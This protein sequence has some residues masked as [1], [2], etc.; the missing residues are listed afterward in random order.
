MTV[1]IPANAKPYKRTATFTETTIPAGLLGDLPDQRVYECF[2][3]VLEE[4]LRDVLAG[5]IHI[6]KDASANLRAY[7]ATRYS[8]ASET[9]MKYAWLRYDAFWSLMNRIT[10]LRALRPS[11]KDGSGKAYAYM[12]DTERLDRRLSEEGADPETYFR[13]YVHHCTLW[14][15]Q[16]CLREVLDPPEHLFLK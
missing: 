7:L 8:P 15:R 16:V 13:A 6:S 9:G 11:V 10:G 1:A 4:Q 5:T 2:D 14:K 12:A 3:L